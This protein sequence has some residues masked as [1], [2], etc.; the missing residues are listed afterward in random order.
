MIF[1]KPNVSDTD[2]KNTQQ[3]SNEVEEKTIVENQDNEQTMLEKLDSEK[4]VVETVTVN[5]NGETVKEKNIINRKTALLVGAGVLLAGTALGGILGASLFNNTNDPIQFDNENDGI[6]DSS[7]TDENNDGIYESQTPINNP[8]QNQNGDNSEVIENPDQNQNGDNSEVIENPDQNQNGDNSEV[9]DNPDQNQNGD[10]SEVIDNPDQNQNG[11]NSEI[12]Q[13]WDPHTAPM[14]SEGTVNDEMSFSEAFAAARTELGAG[15]VF[16]W[17]GQYYGTFYENEV[18]ENHQP[19]IEYPTV[20]YHELPPIE[21]NPDE[22]LMA[23]NQEDIPIEDNQNENEENNQQELQDEN[24]NDQEPEIL[25]YDSN[26]DG[27]TDVVFIDLNNDNEADAIM[28]DINEDGQLTD[29]EVQLIND[30]ESL[31]YNNS[32]LPS[33]GLMYVDADADGINELEVMDADSDLM[34]DHITEVQVDSNN[35]SSNLSNNESITYDGEVSTDVPQ[36]VSDSQLDLYTDDLTAMNDN[37]D[38]Y[39]SWNS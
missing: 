10:N 37:F 24:Q 7:L 29:D 26:E 31:E 30:P 3:T 5:E 4:T 25:G 33:D 35:D 17:Q 38:D 6:P 14:A 39:N 27:N 13:Q 28:V 36:D 15:G 12:N 21:Y 32:N 9:I 18:G 1:N 16:A 34:V 19:L 8:N 2:S 22:Q 23:D 11:D 20:A